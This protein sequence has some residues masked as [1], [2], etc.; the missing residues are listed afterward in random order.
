MDHLFVII[1]LVLQNGETIFCYDEMVSVL[2]PL[3]EKFPIYRFINTVTPYVPQVEKKIDPKYESRLK[4]LK[5]EQENREYLLM[6]RSVDPNQIYDR[7]NVWQGFGEEL[8]AVNRQLMIIVN[9][10]LTVA[11]GFSFGYF[12]IGYA[13][14][15]LNLDITY[16][17]VLGLVIAA[18]VF[19]ADLYFIV[20]GMDNLGEKPIKVSEF[21][22]T[23]IFNKK[24]SVYEIVWY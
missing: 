18:A 19:F 12:G 3:S 13:Y 8:K 24:K 17:M 16:R 5:Q 11:G 2:E 21:A 20:R 9:T 4:R 23:Q 1:Y 15:G 22:N 14:P 7:E 10:L 6:T